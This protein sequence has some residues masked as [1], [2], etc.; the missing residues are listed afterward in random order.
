MAQKMPFIV[1]QSGLENTTFPV[2]DKDGPVLDENGKPQTRKGY[3]P[4]LG[5]ITKGFT[6]EE[7]AKEDAEARNARAK[8]MGIDARYEAVA[9]S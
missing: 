4:D 3:G 2:L 1:R 6:S 8:E 5:A 9:T 7:G